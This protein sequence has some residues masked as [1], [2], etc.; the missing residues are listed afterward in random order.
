MRKITIVCVG[1]LKEKFWVDAVCE[2]TKRISRF[3]DINIVEIDESKI[4]DTSPTSINKAL[5]NEA[6]KIQNIVQNKIVVPLCI[7]GKQ[8]DSVQFADTVAKQTDMGELC[9]VIGSSYGL[10]DTIKKLGA[11][12][13]FGKMTL[14]HQLIRIVLC[15]QIY[16]ALTILNNTAY[17]K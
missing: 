3:A 10:S 11:Q 13:S 17:H 15:E 2:Y 1:K 8:Q 5:D 14:P 12:L 4:A 9:F 6:Q 7:E 16:R